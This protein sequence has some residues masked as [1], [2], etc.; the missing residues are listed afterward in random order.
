MA[1]GKFYAVARGRVPGIY[2]SWP[3]CQAQVI[4]CL[5]PIPAS[6][7]LTNTTRTPH[8]RTTRGPVAPCV[9]SAGRPN[10]GLIPRRRQIWGLVIHVVALSTVE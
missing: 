6:F 1:M 10:C 9:R 4:L 5:L 8:S 2:A 7:P 3:E